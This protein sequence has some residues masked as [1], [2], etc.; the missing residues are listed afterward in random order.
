ME[1]N[2]QSVSDLVSQIKS[3]LE[4][5]FNQVKIEGEVSNLSMSGAG[6]YYFTLKDKDS[7]VSCALFRGDALRNPI[8]KKLK[9]GDQIQCMGAISVY[10]KRG[11]FQVITRW[12][13]PKGKGDLKEKF[14]TLKKKLNAEGLFDLDRKQ[15][16]PKL[17][18]RVGVITAEGAAALQDFLSVYERRSLW[19]DIKV[20]PSLVQ[21]DAAP[22]KIR[23]ALKT[24]KAYSKNHPLD[25]LVL[26]RGG[27]SIEDLW[28]FNDEALAREI[29]D[30]PIP[31]ISAIGHEVDFVLTDFVAD[32]RAETP[33]AA[34][35]LL[36]NQQSKIGEKFSFIQNRLLNQANSI[37]SKI[38]LLLT[39][40]HP[41]YMMSIVSQ[42]I[43]AKSDELKQ[44]KFQDKLE[45]L[46]NFTELYLKLDESIDRIQ[47]AT[48]M[49]FKSRAERLIYTHKLLQSLG[50]NS[51]LG[52]GYAYLENHEN[53][54]M[55]S[56]N[57]F[58]KVE[59]G[60]P[61][62]VHFHDGKIKVV[63]EREG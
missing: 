11:T 52:R 24:A 61:L 53:E 37:S 23:Q 57:S 56:K 59:S 51:V 5:D 54:V 18:R 15:A 10:Q 36:T 58:K 21:G 25:V 27:G 13:K 38:K 26:T 41:K 6:H 9:E 40:F 35:E 29:A 28:A 2:F 30:F 42:R 32:Y 39:K 60:T 16:I 63:Y 3:S 34:A 19:M 17:C 12:L 20:F 46:S 49:A 48:T 50:P 14:E 43:S 7:A 44:I 62:S 55:T 31:V 22:E 47:S 4:T 45:E 8:V 33:T 1:V